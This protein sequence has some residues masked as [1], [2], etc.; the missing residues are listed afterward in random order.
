MNLSLS[1]KPGMLLV[2]SGPSGVGKTTITRHVE[3]QVDAWFSVSMTTRPKTDADTQG[4]D[5]FFV[6]RPEFERAR[7]AGQLL[8]WAEYS[9]NYYGT[10]RQAVEQHLEQGRV[11]LLEIDVNGAAQVKRAM[12]DAFGLF[13]LPPSEQALL[14][15]LRSRRREDEAAIQGRFARAKEEIALAQTSGI[16]NCFI[17]NDELD[18][19][20]RE[21]VDAV[22]SEINRRGDNRV[23]VAGG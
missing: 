5:Y 4:V 13:V 3:K 7:D 2:I 23:T 19:A 12:P 17:V 11:V 18:A 8:E 22:R 1:A 9:G 20:V 10:P 21:A 15:R 14:D 6:T 16:Y